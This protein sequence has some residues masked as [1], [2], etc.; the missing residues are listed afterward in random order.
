MDK[1]NLQVVHNAAA[2]RFEMELQGKQAVI[3][4][5]KRGEDIYNLY[6]A[7][8]P[9]EFEGHGYGSQLVKGALEQIKA[10]GKQFI[11]MCPFIAAYVR[12]HPEYQEFA[13][14]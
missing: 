3:N 5:Q 4:Y 11:P 10:E 9:P 12:R 1:E 14:R 2:S 6:H 7:E 13:T 8:V